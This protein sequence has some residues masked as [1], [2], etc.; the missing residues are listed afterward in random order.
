MRV[1]ESK[2]VWGHQR[3]RLLDMRPQ[4]LAQHSVQDVGTGVVGGDPPPPFR[5]DL[6]LY[7]V[8]DAQFAEVHLDFVNDHAAKWRMGIG[9]RS[10]A[11]GR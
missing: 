2:P 4:R 3:S 6:R 5:V 8:S 9:N 10:G 1:I 7:L 11:C